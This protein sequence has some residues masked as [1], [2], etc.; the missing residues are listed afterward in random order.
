M[1]LVNFI[2]SY[3]IIPA[4]FKHNKTYCSYAD[5]IMPQ[6]FFAVGFAYRMTF[7][8]RLERH[9]FA[10]ACRHAI[11]R[12][13]GLLLIG[14]I[15]Y[16]L[17]DGVKSWAELQKLGLWSYLFTGLKGEFFQTLVHIGVTCLW[18]LPVIASRPI[19]RIIFIIGSGLAHVELSRFF[20]YD[21]ALTHHIIDGGP[22]GFLTWTIPTLVGSLAYDIITERGPRKSIRPYFLWSMALM[23][24]GYGIS[25]FNLVHPLSQSGAAASGISQW[26]IEPPFFPPSRPVDIWTMSQKFGTL[27][28]LTFSAGFSL[29]VYAIFVLAC[30]LRPFQWGIFRTLGQNALAAYIIHGMVADT[31]KPFVPRD[32]PFWYVM[33]GFTLFFG[34]TWVVLRHLEKN[35]LFLKL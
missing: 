7:L 4:L 6:F 2:G 23:I 31:V 14:L 25:C 16:Q 29:A 12:S 34:I 20:Y 24:V 3:A 21:W 27:S 33:T 26:L 30:D 22:L 15:I 17:G 18:I 8:S 5:T 9:G 1:F 11:G 32:A 13:L 35:H 19:I 10:V 28:Y